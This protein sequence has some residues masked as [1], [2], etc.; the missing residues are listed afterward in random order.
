M[1]FCTTC[2]IKNH[3]ESKFCADCGSLINKIS[4]SKASDSLKMPAP[5]IA[6]AETKKLS[7][8]PNNMPASI[9]DPVDNQKNITQW[10]NAYLILLV[11][12]SLAWLLIGSDSPFNKPM[13]DQTETIVTI[14][15]FI[16][17]FSLSYFCVKIQSPEKPK[18]GWL[19]FLLALNI[20]LYIVVLIEPLEIEKPT[21]LD[22]YV[23]YLGTLF[24][25]YFLVK[26][27]YLLRGLRQQTK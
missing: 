14:V 8:S 6:S 4:D 9:T 24:E 27:T 10:A 3:E 19:Y 17:F 5:E 20:F 15:F 26:L 16:V 23:T 12:N 11:I 25:I 7:I 22:Y 1:A 21:R 13:Y 18:V 2:G